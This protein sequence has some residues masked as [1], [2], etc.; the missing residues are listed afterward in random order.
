[1]SSI[2]ASGSG[3][4][5]MLPEHKPIAKRTAV[6]EVRPEE[7]LVEPPDARAVRATQLRAEQ[8]R[9]EARIRALKPKSAVG[10][11]TISPRSR[12]AREQMRALT[13]AV[14]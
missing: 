12:R 8:A 7:R 11:L 2:V 4:A 10:P 9:C 3:W 14:K 13:K 1:M 5:S 6:R